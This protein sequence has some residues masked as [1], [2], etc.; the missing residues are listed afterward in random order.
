MKKNKLTASL[1]A[2]FLWW[3]WVHK[4]YL[5]KT[6]MWIIYLLFCFTLIP[7]FIGFLEWLVYLSQTDEEFDKKFNWKFNT[8]TKKCKFCWEQI[9]IEAIKCRFCQSIAIIEEKE[10]KNKLEKKLVT[11]REDINT[12]DVIKNIK[13]IL[14]IIWKLSLYL[15]WILLIF[16]WIDFSSDQGFLLRFFS[17]LIWALFLPIV[18]K[19]IKEQAIKN[20][21]I[22]KEDSYLKY[23]ILSIIIFTILHWLFSWKNNQNLNNI[24]YSGISYENWPLIEILSDTLNQWNL[25]DYLL[26]VKSPDALK[27]K[28]NWIL[29]NKADTWEWVYKWLF[30]LNNVSTNFN[31]VAIKWNER[32]RKKIAIKRN[33]NKEENSAFNLKIKQEIERQLLF[34]N[35][36]LQKSEIEKFSKKYEAE[37]LIEHI[38]KYNEIS[39]KYLNNKEMWYLAKELKEKTGQIEKIYLPLIDKLLNK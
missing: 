9:R 20:K 7:A 25:K 17:I 33:M 18:Y 1:L 8:E 21:L 2:I 23:Y 16:N 13:E 26:I 38:K 14:L 29:L 34:V 22:K 36:R 30:T 27:I 12:K 24:D 37:S 11:K 31:I 10:E 3:L 4:F 15:I 28:V 32:S 19:L 39:N 5:W 6:W 35:L